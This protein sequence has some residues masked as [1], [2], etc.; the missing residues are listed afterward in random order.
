MEGKL[1]IVVTPVA[2]IIPLLVLT[3]SLSPTLTFNKELHGEISTEMCSSFSS[4]Y[5]FQWIF[6]SDDRILL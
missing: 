6:F 2:P 4:R 5:I 1:F 3:L